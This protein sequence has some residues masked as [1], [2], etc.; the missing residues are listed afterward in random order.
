MSTSL[1]HTLDEVL[2]TRQLLEHPFYRRWEV[3]ALSSEE[4]THYAE[5]YRYF[6]AM[7]PTFLEGLSAGL[8]PGMARDLVEANL[9][10][11]ITAPSHLDLFDRFADYYGVQDASMTPATR[12]LVDA[13][14]NVQ[15]KGSVAALAGLF[16]Y[17]SQGAAIADSKAEGLVEFYGISDAALTFWTEHGSIEGDH[18]KWTLDA[19]A[20]LEP[21]LD[22]VTDAALL[23]ADAW[24]AFLD[25][26]EL[27]SA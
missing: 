8:A 6:E 18:A 14:S 23:V 12:R 10:D 7:L 21:D 22:E 25:E 20:T 4:L 13:Y 9:A 5:Q 17:E 26:R 16:A 2:A 27:Q 11:E 15:A 3:G 1:Q 19:L 24:W